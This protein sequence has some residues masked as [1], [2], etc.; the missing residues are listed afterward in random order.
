MGHRRER[1]I[2]AIA[3][4]GTFDGITPRFPTLTKLKGIPM[5]STEYLALSDNEICDIIEA[6]QSLQNLKL[7]NTNA[8][9]SF[10]IRTLP[11]DRLVDVARILQA[12]KSGL[13]KTLSGR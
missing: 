2:L 11:S 8:E 10:I 3:E 12:R 5:Q 1:L 13:Q 6:L 7:R 9:Q 4:I